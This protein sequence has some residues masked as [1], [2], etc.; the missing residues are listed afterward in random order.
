MSFGFSRNIWEQLW[1][2]TF[3]F[4]LV[5]LHYF[6]IHRYYVDLYNV[7]LAGWPG[8]PA[9]CLAWQNLKVGHYM[10]TFQQNIFISPILLGT[11]DL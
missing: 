1:C 6:L 8:R 11:I 3:R 10:Q 4:L 5:L 2:L 7:C 9:S